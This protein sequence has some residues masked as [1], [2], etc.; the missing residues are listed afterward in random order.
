MS[1]YLDLSFYSPDKN[2]RFDHVIEKGDNKFYKG[3]P[4]YFN[5]CQGQTKEADRDGDE[6]E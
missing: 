4:V 2:F 3:P 1:E 5:K 6:K